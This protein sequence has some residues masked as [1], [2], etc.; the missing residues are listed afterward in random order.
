M[1]IHTNYKHSISEPEVLDYDN[2]V[3]AKGQY[4]PLSDVIARVSRGEML[5]LHD[6]T[7]DNP[8]DCKDNF[9]VLDTYHDVNTRVLAHE[10]AEAEEKAKAEKEAEKQRIIDEYEAEKATDS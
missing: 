4:M 3:T 9:D 8:M 5:D 1:K 6:Y 2:S 7:K 10:K